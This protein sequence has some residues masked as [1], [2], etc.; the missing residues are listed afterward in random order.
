[1]RLLPIQHDSPERRLDWL[2]PWCH[3][4]LH[5]HLLRR[6]RVV[7]DRHLVQYSWRLRRLLRLFRSRQLF[8]LQRRRR[9]GHQAEGIRR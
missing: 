8:E 1:M 3:Q 4:H 2:D 9:Q 5:G 7:L 6:T